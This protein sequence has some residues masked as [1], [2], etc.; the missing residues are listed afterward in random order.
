[1]TRGHPLG[2]SIRRW[3]PLAMFA[4]SGI[5]RAADT[6]GELH[7]H[8]DAFSA[9]GV[10]IAWAV[11]RGAS[12]AAATVVLRV[13]ASPRDYAAVAVDGVDPFTQQR[14][15]VLARRPL[16]ASIDVTIARAQFADFPR[17]ELRFFKTASDL[18][19]SPALTVYYLGVPDTTPEFASE[20]QMNTYLAGRIAQLLATPAPR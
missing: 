12:E 8:S 6:A 11:S 17:T 1:M 19:A 7:G 4:L 18:S 14:Q 9:S 5:G 15:P 16:T 3:L 13:A 20:A 2:R 10:A